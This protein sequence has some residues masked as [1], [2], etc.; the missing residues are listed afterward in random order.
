MLAWV[1][2]HLLVSFITSRLTPNQ[3]WKI[4]PILHP[5]KLG[6]ESGIHR[7]LKIKKWKKKLP[8]AGG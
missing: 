8:D 1:G 6:R 5:Y 7:V 4:S 2:I 3:V